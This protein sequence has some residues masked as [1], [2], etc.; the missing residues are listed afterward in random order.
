M[1]K[2]VLVLLADG[3]E[4]IEA[5]TC[6]DVLRRA[7]LKVVTASITNR[8]VVCGS[9]NVKIQAEARLCDFSGLPDALVLPGGMPGAENL[10]RSL[11]VENLIKKCHKNKKIIAAI[12][13]SPAIVLVPSEVL[14]GKRAT[15]YP[16]FKKNLSAKTTYV[17]KK[18]VIDGH[19]ITSQG[20]GTTFYFALK[21]VEALRGIK[22]AKAIKKRALVR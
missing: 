19:I 15:C 17:D 14:T 12:C 2:K 22:V 9:H 3:F 6:I 18:V 5:V 13:A 4:E 7:D 10:A 16:Q 21:I 8:G 1:Q 11:K 20:P